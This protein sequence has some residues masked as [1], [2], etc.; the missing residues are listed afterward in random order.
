MP[1]VRYGQV[2]LFNNYFNSPGNNYCIR[3]RIDAEVLAENNYFEDVKNPWERYVT[4][5]G[6]SPGKL[7]AS[8][9]IEVSTTRYVNPEPD[10]GNQS[11]LIPGDDA[12][13]TPPYSYMPDDAATVKNAVMAGAGPAG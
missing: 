1:S 5:A 11:F 4:E 3:T 9:N 10:D 8:G 2:H 13:F 6:G 7:R 12:V